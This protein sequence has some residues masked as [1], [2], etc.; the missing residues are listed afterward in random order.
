M[1]FMLHALSSVS[2]TAHIEGQSALRGALFV[3]PRRQQTRANP[4]T[5]V[6][7]CVLAAQRPHRACPTRSPQRS[8]DTARGGCTT[9]PCLQGFPLTRNHV[10]RKPSKIE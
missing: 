9:T 2:Y 10:C 5:S 1:V 7:S 6:G 8:E 4:Q 3:E